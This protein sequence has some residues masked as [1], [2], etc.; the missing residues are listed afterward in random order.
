MRSRRT[1]GDIFRDRRGSA[2]I[3]F[4]LVIGVLLVS[5]GVALDLYRLRSARAEA[6]ES[7]DS[8]VLAAASSQERKRAGLKRVADGF[9]EANLITPLLEGARPETTFEHDETTD[10]IQMT[11]SSGVPTTFMGLV[12]IKRMPFTVLAEA[13]RGVAQPV[14]LAL[15]L[16]NTWS[17]SDVDSLGVK[18]IDALKTAS[19]ALVGTVMH[20][21]DGN[22]K[23]SIVPYADY[24]NVGTSNRGASWLDVPADYSTTSPRTCSPTR[25]ESRNCRKGAAKTCTS[26]TDGII[27]TS[28]CTPNICDTVVINE[29]TCSGPHTTNYRWYGCVGSRKEGSWRLN[30]KAGKTYPGLLATSQNCLNPILPLTHEKAKVESAISKLVVNIGGYK[31]LTYI[32]AG[33]IWGVATLSPDAPFIEGAAY[34]PDNRRPRKILVLMTDGENTLRFVPS[35]G[36][37]QAFNGNARNQSVQLTAANKDTA[38][39]CEYAKEQGIEVYTV[40]LAVQSNAARTLLQGCASDPAGAFDAADTAALTDAFAAIA[41]AITQVRLVK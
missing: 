11:L 21:G 41:R 26:V 32:P 23:V 33:L 25:T 7:V 30:D 1:P 27:V 9:L 2:T 14:E 18:K 35:N 37:H 15:V 19:K 28:D 36:L 12:G 29:E 31:P 40:L 39:I 8:A 13:E 5:G 17:M 38:A 4:A 10:R 24:V 6:Q 22:V 20:R 34:D 3:I 16:D